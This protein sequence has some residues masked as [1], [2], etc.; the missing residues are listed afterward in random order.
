MPVNKQI[1]IL[2]T[3]CNFCYL[4]ILISDLMFSTY[5]PKIIGDI[6]LFVACFIDTIQTILNGCVLPRKTVVCCFFEVDLL[7]PSATIQL[8]AY[9]KVTRY[10]AHF[11]KH[12]KRFRE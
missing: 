10:L 1:R 11:L 12:F 7:P 8:K 6:N 9:L 3:E 5:R 2:V 4:A